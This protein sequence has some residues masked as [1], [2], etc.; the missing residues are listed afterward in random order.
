[1]KKALTMIL[2]GG[3]MALAGHLIGEYQIASFG[4]VS[5]VLVTLGGLAAI[6]GAFRL[7]GV[8][9]QEEW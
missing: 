8:I 6:I 2:G 7:F 5:G 4:D 9:T 3:A 1:M